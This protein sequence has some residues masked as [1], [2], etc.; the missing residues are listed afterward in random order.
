MSP[1]E[2]LSLGGDSAQ[3]QPGG[4]QKKK[5]TVI[6]P[7]WPPFKTEANMSGP[8]GHPVL[9]QVKPAIGEACPR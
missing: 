5:R 1:D 7:H 6:S 8:G 2:C 9:I 3:L 4:R